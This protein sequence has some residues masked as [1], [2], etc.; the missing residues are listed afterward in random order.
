MPNVKV[1][2]VIEF[3]YTLN[4]ENITFFPDFRMQY[5]IPVNYSEYVTEIPEFFIY[6]PIL[7]GFRK[8]QSD[9]KIVNGYQNFPNQYNQTVNLSFQQINSSYIAENVPA[10]KS[11]PFVDNV[12]NYRS[13]VIHELEM[14]RFPDAPQKNYSMTWD[15]VANMIFKEPRFG[16][17]LNEAAYFAAYLNPVIQNAK[18]ETEKAHLIFCLCQTHHA[19]GW[20]LWLP[21]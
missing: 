4:S 5:G 9:S 21:D 2:S 7:T 16:K 13:A 18:T 11:E 12:S 10:L 19:L 3:K 15:G 14:T 20:L 17:E 1:G 8:I 6:K